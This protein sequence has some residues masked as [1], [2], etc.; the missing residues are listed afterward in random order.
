MVTDFPRG[1]GSS[2]TPLEH[3][4][5]MKNVEN[6]VLMETSEDLFSSATHDG[7]SKKDGKKRR[8]DGKQKQSGAVG[9]KPKRSQDSKGPSSEADVD[10]ESSA[11][12]ASSLD[13][14]KK[15]PEMLRY[16]ASTIF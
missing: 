8:L 1:G 14:S 5:I 11:V 12:K 13:I 9:K 10:G 7:K 3:R 4:E 16:K 2:L 15:N 6:E